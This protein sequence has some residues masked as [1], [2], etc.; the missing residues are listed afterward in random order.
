MTIPFLSTARSLPL[1]LT[2]APAKTSGGRVPPVPRL[3]DRLGRRCIWAFIGSVPDTTKSARITTNGR[4]QFFGAIRASQYPMVRKIAFD[5]GFITMNIPAENK[6]V[7]DKC[8][9][10]TTD[11]T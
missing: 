10:F 8:M 2:T 9:P 11:K 1:K 7:Q 6:D 3:P 4:D 5:Q